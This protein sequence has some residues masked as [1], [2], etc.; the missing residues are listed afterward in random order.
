[1]TIITTFYVDSGGVVFK[2]N[3]G[4]SLIDISPNIVSS[5]W[6]LK[7]ILNDISTFGVLGVTHGLSIEDSGFTLN[8]IFNQVATTGSDTIVGAMYAAKATRAFESYPVGVTSGN[9]KMAGNCICETY[10]I[11]AV[12]KKHVEA[13]A[14]FVVEGLTTWSF[15]S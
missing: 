10:E 9:R 13:T 4:S 12:T 3:N 7:F 8:L 2:L 11:I 14:T 1:M 15:V 5:R 6:P